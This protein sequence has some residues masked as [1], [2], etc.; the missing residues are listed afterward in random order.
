LLLD[1]AQPLL[2]VDATYDVRCQQ[3]QSYRP[4][5]LPN[6]RHDSIYDSPNERLTLHQP[7]PLDDFL[8]DHGTEY[9]ACQMHM[10]YF[11]A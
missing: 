5:L 7:Q 10:P 11:V 9:R 4:H 3:V 8:F 1:E 6:F 2:H